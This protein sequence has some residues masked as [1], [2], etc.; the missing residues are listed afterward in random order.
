[1][2]N[3]GQRVVLVP[4]WILGLGAVLVA[5]LVQH[6]APRRA[7][8]GVVPLVVTV[9]VPPQ[10]YFVERIGGERVVVNVMVPPGAL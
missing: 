8:A 6:A 2:R 5:G 9:S 4:A 10:A 1:M 7:L 3:R